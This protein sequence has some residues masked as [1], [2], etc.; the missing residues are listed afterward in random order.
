MQNL[1]SRVEQ[2]LIPVVARWAEQDK[3]LLFPLFPLIASGESLEEAQLSKDLNI[4]ADA[5]S[6]ALD[7]L[8]AAIDSLEF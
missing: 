4:G 1:A 8:L 7:M 3:D 2:S 6:A 5:F